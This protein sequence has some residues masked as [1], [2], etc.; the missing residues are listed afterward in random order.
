MAD[1]IYTNTKGGGIRAVNY[2]FVAG[3]LPS[4]ANTALPQMPQKINMHEHPWAQ[5]NWIDYA[6]AWNQN[7][8]E[9]VAIDEIGA[10]P[11]YQVPVGYVMHRLWVPPYTVLKSIGINHKKEVDPYGVADTSLDGMSYDVIANLVDVTTTP[12]TPV[13]GALAPTA[14]PAGFTGIVASTAGRMIGQVLPAA[15]GYETG[16]DGVLLSFQIVTP[17]T[18]GLSNIKGAITIQA[19][20]E[21]FNA[22]IR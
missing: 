9:C 16:A 20:M 17:P 7:D 14:V 2:S 22:M 19:N 12:E 1:L 5:M 3:Y 10:G 8:K 11:I 13:I 21:T 15:G 6:P 4:Q 18:T